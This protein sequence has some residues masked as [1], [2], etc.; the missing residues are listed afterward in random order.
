MINEDFYFKHFKILDI[1]D[2]YFPTL[3]EIDTLEDS[4]S[5]DEFPVANIKGTFVF[6]KARYQ[7]FYGQKYLTEAVIQ[8]QVSAIDYSILPFKV[9]GVLED[10]VNNTIKITSELFTTSCNLYVPSAKERFV[11]LTD[12][13]FTLQSADNDDEGIYNHNPEIPGNPLW[14][15]LNINVNP[16]QDQSFIVNNT[17][18]FADTYVCSCPDY[19]HAIIRNPQ[20]L[21]EDGQVNN[22]Q[23]RS[24]VLSANSPS[25][26]DSVGIT[27]SASIVS[28]WSTLNYQNSFK[29]CKHTIAAQFIDKIRILEPNQLPTYE[30]RIEFETKLA[31]D[32]ENIQSQFSNQ[33]RNS[34]T[35]FVEIIYTLAAALNLNKVELAYV[36]TTR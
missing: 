14:Q 34:E 27:K 33:L 9:L 29:I 8:D 6:E 13:S 23:K 30:K 19:L 26:Y 32:I 5:I 12:N 20:T 3:Q 16:W 4:F 28:S 1:A 35:S 10:S 11:V 25:T 17:I 15:K 2:E 24:P 7:K 31:K 21:N 36:I 18:T 22:K